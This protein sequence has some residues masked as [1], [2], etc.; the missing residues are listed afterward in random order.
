[1]KENYELRQRPMLLRRTPVI[2]RIDGRAFHTYTRNMQRPFDPRLRSTMLVAAWRTARAIQ[3]CQ[4]V[5]QQSD[6]A[7]FLITDY[8][9]LVTDAWF[10]YNQAKLCSI[11]ASIFTAHF[12]RKAATWNPETEL[13]RQTIAYFDAR[14]FNVPREEVVNYFLWR[15][16]DW[17]RNSVA[18]LGRAHFSHKEMLNKAIPDVHEMLHTKGINWAK[19][20]AWQRNGSWLI[21]S[22][23]SW[24]TK[25]NIMP[26]YDDISR[27]LEARIYPD[28]DLS[29]YPNPELKDVHTSQQHDCDA[30][31]TALA[32]D[33]E[34]NATCRV[35]N[36]E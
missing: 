5:Y 15:M 23:A 34:C 29:I 10:S 31:D 20:E 3:G 19:L 32:R 28:R 4:A 30:H 22:G 26:N 35:Y 6:E 17:E 24:S 11:A 8:A 36:G 14:A 18:M 9:D 27:F 25:T 2:V 13:P 1:M 12:N 16:L 33:P 21:G 7:S